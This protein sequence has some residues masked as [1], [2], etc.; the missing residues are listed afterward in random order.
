MAVIRKHQSRGR[1]RRRSGSATP[2]AP[3]GEGSP[4]RCGVRVRVCVFGTAPVFDAGQSIAL[5][6]S[7]RQLLYRYIY[8]SAEIIKVNYPSLLHVMTRFRPARHAATNKK[9]VLPL[10]QRLKLMNKR[11]RLDLWGVEDAIERDDNVGLSAAAVEKLAACEPSLFL[12]QRDDLFGRV[13]WL[14]RAVAALGKRVA[15]RAVVL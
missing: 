1:R 9:L 6:S 12:I 8:A 11:E 5:V 10:H 15:C 14:D 4:R 7:S 3:S 13:R 2:H